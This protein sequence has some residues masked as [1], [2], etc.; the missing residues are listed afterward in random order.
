[1]GVANLLRPGIGVT[2]AADTETGAIATIART[3]PKTLVETIVHV[4]PSSIIDAMAKGD[5]LQIVAFS[6]LFAFAV[7]AMG[8][9]GRPIYRACES[10]SQII[11]KFTG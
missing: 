4:F 1:M 7:G 3:Q 2:L 6:V 8:E 11:F 9:R 10:L 5:V